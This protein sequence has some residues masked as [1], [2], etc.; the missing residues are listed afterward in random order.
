M[1]TPFFFDNLAISP[2][3]IVRFCSSVALCFAPFVVTHTQ[4]CNRASFSVHYR[5]LKSRPPNSLS[6]SLS[7]SFSIFK[8]SLSDEITRASISLIF[9]MRVTY[10]GANFLS[11]VSATLS[12]ACGIFCENAIWIETKVANP[13]EAA[14]LNHAESI[15]RKSNS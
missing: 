7:L 10:R 6:L 8:T 12:T 15:K 9:C 11:P 14:S 4:T 3:V 2:L 5:T 1:Y 13:M